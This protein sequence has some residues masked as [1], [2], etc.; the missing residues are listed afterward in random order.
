[1]HL[2]DAFIAAIKILILTMNP[3][4]LVKFKNRNN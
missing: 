1:M 4:N 2:A 3:H